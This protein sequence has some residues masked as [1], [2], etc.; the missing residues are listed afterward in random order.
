LFSRTIVNTCPIGGSLGFAEAGAAPP[1][2]AASAA[3]IRNRGRV[4]NV[5]PTSVLRIWGRAERARR[6]R[7]KERLM[8]IVTILIIIIL[9]LLA[10]YL[11][12]RVF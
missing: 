10:I 11:F 8:S 6:P 12:R 5:R 9:V 4:K 3:T 2:R 1:T 7:Q